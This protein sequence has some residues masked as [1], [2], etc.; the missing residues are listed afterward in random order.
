VT[1]TDTSLT[2][3]IKR[4]EDERY[5]TRFIGSGGRVLADIP[6]LA[7]HYRFRSTDGYVRAVVID[8]NNLM[9]WTQPTFVRR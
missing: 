3:T 1:A 7:P 8:S 5:H 6:G 9:A 2:L 4:T